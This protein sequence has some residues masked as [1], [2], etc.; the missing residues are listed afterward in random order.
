M[1]VLL[2]THILYWWL[3]ERRRLSAFAV[4]TVIQADEVYVSAASLW[5]M[6][7]KIR[8]GKLK[9]EMEEITQLLQSTAF[10]ELSV[11]FRHAR[12]VATLPMHHGDPFDRLLV[13]QAV[14]EPLHLLTADTKLKPYSDL[15]ICV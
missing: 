9:G 2:D 15:V 13:A 7:I 10:Q 6:A 3:F 11:S 8:L 12:R 1:G 5:E 14:T 4:K